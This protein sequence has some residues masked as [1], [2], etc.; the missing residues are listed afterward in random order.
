MYA[1]KIASESLETRHLLWLGI[2][3]AAMAS[4]GR[5]GRRTE[6]WCSSEHPFSCAAAPRG[7][8]I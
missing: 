4:M 3:G 1:Q 8:D 6:F 7:S 5:P 2:A